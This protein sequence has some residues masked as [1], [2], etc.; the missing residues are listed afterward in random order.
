MDGGAVVN[1]SDAKRICSHC[2]LPDGLRCLIGTLRAPEGW[3]KDL[4]ET[5]E[6]PAGRA[7]CTSCAA[8]L[9]ARDAAV[10]L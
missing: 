5:V 10:S 2:L 7:L 6:I 4:Y 8:E 1:T 3:V 9:T